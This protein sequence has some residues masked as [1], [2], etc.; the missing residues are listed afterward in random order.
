MI[1]DD[2]LR[3]IR[4]NA[5]TAVAVTICVIVIVFVVVKSVVE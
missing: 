1:R 5:L 3:A 4:D 2:D